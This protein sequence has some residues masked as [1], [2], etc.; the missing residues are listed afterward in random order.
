MER[1]TYQ[2]IEI[3]PLGWREVL[4]LAVAVTVVLALVLVFGLLF[5]LL[6]PVVLVAGLIARWWLGREL[7]KES[8]RAEQGTIEAEYEEIEIERIEPPGRGWGPRR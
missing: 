6:L 3:R 8:R 7:R 2:R 4:A 1:Q 5:L